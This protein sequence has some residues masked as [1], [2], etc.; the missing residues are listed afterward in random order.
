MQISDFYPFTDGQVVTAEQWN[1]LFQAIKDGSFM[2]S[3]TDIGNI[4]ARISTLE[5]NMSYFINLKSRISR[6]EQKVLSNG[7]S[8]YSL[9]FLPNLDSEHL[10][11]NG[12]Y[13][14]K[15]MPGFDGDYSI[16]GRTITFSNS[17]RNEIED[18]DVLTVL[19]TT[20][21]EI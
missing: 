15:T 9:A 3:S 21:E 18:G 6:R 5:Q 13:L 8:V 4:V 17:L 7:E 16:D 10:F 14:H 2:L 1:M 11:L 12:L 20:E 19:Y